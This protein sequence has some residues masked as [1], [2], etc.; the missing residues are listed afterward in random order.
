MIRDHSTLNKRL[1]N[2]CQEITALLIR[3]YSTPVKILQHSYQEI[4]VLSVKMIEYF[5]FFVLF[6]LLTYLYVRTKRYITFLKMADKIISGIPYDTPQSDTKRQK[7]IKCMLTG[8][9]KQYL[10]KACTK[11]Q[12]N[13]LSNEEV[14]K[15]FSNYEAKL[16]GQMVKSLGKSIINMYSMG[17]CA[18]LGISDQDALS[19]DLE[20]DPFL[21]SALQR[22]TCELYYRFGS[23]LASLS[24]GLISSRHYLSER[25]KNEGDKYDENISE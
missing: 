5:N 2:F 24:V 1:Q 16:S 15:L 10:G 18:Y 14:N 6:T 20:N 9:S 7:I 13:K 4:T 19:E 17:A 8:N 21:N 22:F 3:D 12:I 11:D 25:N 23:F